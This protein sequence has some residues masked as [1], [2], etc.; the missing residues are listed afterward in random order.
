MAG[1][2]QES[3]CVWI[4][5]GYD[6]VKMQFSLDGSFIVETVHLHVPVQIPQAPA[7]VLPYKAVVSRAHNSG[8]QDIVDGLP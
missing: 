6:V 4:Q 8:Y 7:Y 3:L 2:H 1:Q 5:G